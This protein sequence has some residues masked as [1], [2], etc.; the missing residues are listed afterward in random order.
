M[1]DVMRFTAQELRHAAAQ[2][3]AGAVIVAAHDRDGE[4]LAVTVGAF[5]LVSME[6]P[7]VSFVPGRAPRRLREAG[8]TLFVSILSAGQ[9]HLCRAVESG[10]TSLLGW[11]GVPVAAGALAHLECRVAQLVRAGEGQLAVCDVLSVEVHA[12]DAPLAFF[13]GGYGSVAP[14]WLVAAGPEAPE[15]RRVAA[16]GRTEME[17]LAD[18]LGAYVTAMA[19]TGD[20]LTLVATAGD[21]HGEA[22]ITQLGSR[23]PFVPPLGATEAAWGSRALRD[24]WLGELAGARRAHAEAVL[25]RIRTR[26]W[27]ITLGTGQV[28]VEYII[29]RATGRDGTAARRELA[30]ALYRSAAGFNSLVIDESV[31]QQLRA[32]AVPVF[33]RHGTPTLTLSAWA[34]FPMLDW[35]EIEKY[36]DAVK[37]TAERISALAAGFSTGTEKS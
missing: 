22:Q 30:D 21:P 14:R 12:A 13:R 19:R 37:I 1:T 9:E 26:G 17:T 10:D 8:G 28:E 6:P 34:P 25:D 16:I 2:C 3:P 15:G 7:M 24:E 23:I 4:L 5:G 36:I 18:D 31:P 27:A 32:V 29:R 20:S 33:D 11:C 35:P